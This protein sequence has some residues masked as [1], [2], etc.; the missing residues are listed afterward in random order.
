MA[1]APNVY[2]GP[3]SFEMGMGNLFEQLLQSQDMA[4]LSDLDTAFS[5]TMQQP[6]RRLAGGGVGSLDATRR[7]T[8]PAYNPARAELSQN[9][10]QNKDFLNQMLAGVGFAGN[11]ILGNYYNIL[12]QG[13]SMPGGGS[14]FGS[15]LGGLF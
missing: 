1:N 13:K 2:S 10:M 3:L 8:A 5:G 7:M 14:L 9:Y 11:N 15:I 4:G 6:L 12:A